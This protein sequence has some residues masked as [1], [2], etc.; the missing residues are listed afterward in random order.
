MHG[1][2]EDSDFNFLKGSTVEQVCL[3]QYDTQLHLNPGGSLRMEGSYVHR[4]GIRE[5][6]Q[7]RSSCGPNELHRLLGQT[8]TG[9]SVLP[10][11]SLTLSFSNG[12]ELMLV[13]DSDQYE[14]FLIES[15]KGLM[16]I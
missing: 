2:S 7:D 10:P 11:R 1:F 14:S 13:D 5:I 15:P 12:D 3:G 9:L 6:H 16:V 8:I 4:F